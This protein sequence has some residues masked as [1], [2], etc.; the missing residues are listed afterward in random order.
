[1]ASLDEAFNT[2][3]KPE[4]G[5]EKEFLS[6]TID[7]TYKTTIIK[8]EPIIIS[9]HIKTNDDLEKYKTNP[10]EYE[11]FDY[12]TEEFIPDFVIA[13]YVFFG[14]F[15]LLDLKF[16]KL[17]YCDLWKIIEK[18]Y[19]KIQT[20]YKLKSDI[21]T[22]DYQFK[23]YIYKASKYNYKDREITVLHSISNKLK[24]EI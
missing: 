2:I 11:P 8:E 5:K 18:D 24:N 21:Q 1:M 10:P 23:D 15:V 6:N 9:E 3:V 17:E 20:V 4:K 7:I 12:D 22:F 13:D 16:N 19:E 14:Y